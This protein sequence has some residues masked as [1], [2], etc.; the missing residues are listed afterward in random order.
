LGDVSLCKLGKYYKTP[1]VHPISIP[2]SFAQ[3]AIVKQIDDKADG[4]QTPA[5]QK[6]IEGRLHVIQ[7]EAVMSIKRLND[8]H[9]PGK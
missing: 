9:L 8:S 4:T 7:V 1:S 2:L 5:T 6:E 3:Y